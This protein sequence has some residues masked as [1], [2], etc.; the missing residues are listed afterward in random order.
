MNCRSKDIHNC[1]AVGHPLATA[2]QKSPPEQQCRS[3]ESNVLCRMHQLIVQSRL[4]QE[5]NVPE[6]YT[7]A[8][9]YPCGERAG[10][11]LPCSADHGLLYCLSQLDAEG[12]RKS[13]QHRS[14]RL[15]YD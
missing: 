9:N 13:P 2:M 11:S 6:P 8:V 1:R 4:V 15:S 14:S 3:K 5:R 7:D 10:N 12:N